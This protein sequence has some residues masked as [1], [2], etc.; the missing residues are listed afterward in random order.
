LYY[1]D[2]IK[3]SFLYASFFAFI[4]TIFL[5]FYYTEIDLLFKIIIIIF[6]MFILYL[7]IKKH[8]FIDKKPI[9]SYNNLSINIILFIIY[10]FFL[11]FIDTSFYEV[12]FSRVK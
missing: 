9:I 11:K 3:I 4:F 12:Y 10:L 5:Q 6:E 2:F 8:I 1:F 7:N